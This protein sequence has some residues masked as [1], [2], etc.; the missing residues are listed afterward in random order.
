MEQERNQRRIAKAKELAARRDSVAAQ[1]AARAAQTLQIDTDQFL[2]EE[3]KAAAQ[4]AGTDT[5]SASNM[6]RH[7]TG[8][9]GDMVTH[10]G[11]LKKI[12]HIEDG[13]DESSRVRVV[14]RS[15]HGKCRARWPG[16]PDM[17]VERLHVAHACTAAPSRDTL[18]NS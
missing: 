5:G 8:S 7:V 15:A 17:P 6:H 9:V 12:T 10:R 3:L 1:E 14:L 4:A 18:P 2:L 11:L 13:S 16:L